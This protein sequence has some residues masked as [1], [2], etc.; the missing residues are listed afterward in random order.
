MLSHSYWPSSPTCGIP[1][2][3]Q[4]SSLRWTLVMCMSWTISDHK[5]CFVSEVEMCAGS[6]HLPNISKYLKPLRP[7]TN[8]VS[9]SAVPCGSYSSHRE[10]PKMSFLTFQQWP[11]HMVRLFQI[12]MVKDG[13]LE[14]RF[15]GPYNTILNWCFDT[16]DNTYQFFVSSQQPTIFDKRDAID[17]QVEF[18]VRNDQ[19]KPVLIVEIKDGS[20]NALPSTRHSAD[21]QIHSRFD[22]LLVQCPL[23]HLYAIS[24][25]GIGMRVY[26]GSVETF[27]VEPPPTHRPS[28]IYVLP[29]TFLKGEWVLDVLSQGGFE[30]MKAI[31]RDIRTMA[32]R[33]EWLLQIYYLCT[34][35][36]TL[37]TYIF[38][39]KH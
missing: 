30:R 39:S 20:H 35:A 38:N 27:L 4:T 24:F 5:R 25:L 14:S 3:Q 33:V 21:A 28:Q 10:K 29:P 2:S 8:W 18:I 32:D 15:Y 6:L 1:T 9:W 37:V 26:S 31:V 13:N 16:A 23:P 19:D 11:K 22:E 17:F 12:K 34:S 36:S 7:P